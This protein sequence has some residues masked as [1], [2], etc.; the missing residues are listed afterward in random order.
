M[1]CPAGDEKELVRCGRELW[2]IVADVHGRPVM[3]GVV[4]LPVEPSHVGVLPQAQEHIGLLPAHHQVV[5][6]VLGVRPSENLAHI[7][8]PRVAMDRKVAPAESV[9][10][11]EPD[12]ERGAEGQVHTRTEDLGRMGSHN[13]LERHLHPGA[14]G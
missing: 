9:E 6:L 13:Q 5:G 3:V 4:G 8:R 14:A 2:H 10:V 11:V 7:T 12:R 1:R